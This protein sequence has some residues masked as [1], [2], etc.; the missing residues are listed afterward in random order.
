M[1]L[2]DMMKQQ[3]AIAEII[4]RDP[5]VASMSSTV[6][7]GG[8]NSG[9][10]TGTIFVVLK[11]LKERVSADQVVEELRPKVSHEPGFRVIIQ[12]PPSINIGGGV[13]G[14]RFSGA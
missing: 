10:N 3:N 14:G 8:R 11:P 13:S 1:S 9:G 12:N 2:Q 7:A 4:R 6:G 5:N